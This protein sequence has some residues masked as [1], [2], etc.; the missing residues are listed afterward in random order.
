MTTIEVAERKHIPQILEL[1]Q[2]LMDYHAAFDPLFEAR[3]N[4]ARNWE[5]Y[6]RDLMR[7]RDAR[8]FIAVKDDEIIG[9][10]VCRAAAHPPVFKQEY[11]G[12]IMD[13]AV[14]REHQRQGTGTM[15]LETIYKWVYKMG[16]DRIELQVVPNN[17]LGYSFWKKHGFADYLHSLYKKL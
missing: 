5:H 8:V 16:L 7:L 11:Y 9:Y 2:Q 4:G 12:L 15:M 13:M 14:K 1:W 17:N 6:I 3:P 10:S